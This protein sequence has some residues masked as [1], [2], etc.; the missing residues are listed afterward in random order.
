MGVGVGGKTELAC[1]FGGVDSETR[2]IRFLLFFF[3]FTIQFSDD[4]HRIYT[5]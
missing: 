4:I 2:P 5:A 3:F 1:V